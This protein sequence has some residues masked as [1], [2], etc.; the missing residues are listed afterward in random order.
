MACVPD[1]T[2][3]KE[4]LLFE[5]EMTPRPTET[6]L[7]SEQKPW[8][9]RVHRS[10]KDD[11][12]RSRARMGRAWGT[13]TVVS[14][15]MRPLPPPAYAAAPPPAEGSRL[16]M[17]LRATKEL[18]DASKVLIVVLLR[19]PGSEKKGGKGE[20]VPAGTRESTRKSEPPRNGS[21]AD[22]LKNV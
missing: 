11:K 5:G 10:K 18:R 20:E 22:D 16:A 21:T 9:A 8:T 4:A 15:T 12:R 1:V 7:R 6:T 3:R 17:S 14:V 2:E 13:R 19:P